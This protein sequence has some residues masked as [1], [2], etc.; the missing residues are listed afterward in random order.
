MKQ[1]LKCEQLLTLDNYYRQHGT[2]HY[3]V[4]KP[5]CNI[6]S[7]L[8]YRKKKAY[9]LRLSTEYKKTTKGKSVVHT[10]YLRRKAKGLTALCGARFRANSKL[11][12]A[13][14]LKRYKQSPKG[15]ASSRREVA[16]RRMRK[17]TDASLTHEQ[18]SAILTTYNH[19]CAYCGST[20]QL[21]Q[22]HYFPISKG[23]IH[24][25]GNVVP[26]CLTCNM[27][28]SARHPHKLF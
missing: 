13:T 9:Y 17:R 27:K 25:K 4:C 24:A 7:N 10:N 23:G 21:T 18:W 22:D 14:I 26:A 3:A 19:R 15:K 2:G 11:K 16:V 20:E 6:R 28:K 8:E 1:C 5:C 12:R